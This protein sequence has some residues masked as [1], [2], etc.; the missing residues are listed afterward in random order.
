MTKA[1]EVELLEDHR[2]PL[3]PALVP[4][5]TGRSAR[6]QANMPPLTLAASRE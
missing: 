1:F 6:S 4:R 3:P 2:W 5:T